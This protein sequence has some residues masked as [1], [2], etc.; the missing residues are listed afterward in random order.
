MHPFRPTKPMIRICGIV[1]RNGCIALHL[2]S[3]PTRHG[4]CCNKSTDQTFSTL[5]NQISAFWYCKETSSYL[6]LLIWP[7]IK[8]TICRNQISNSSIFSI[9]NFIAT[10]LRFHLFY[11]DLIWSANRLHVCILHFLS[12]SSIIW[13]LNDFPQSPC[14]CS[15]AAYD[16]SGFQIIVCH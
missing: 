5:L 16:S 3:F 8:H 10:K 15:K 9:F 4:H 7:L 1:G 11:N 2:M 12:A 6:F 14:L 13:L